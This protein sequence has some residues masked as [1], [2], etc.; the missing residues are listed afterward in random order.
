ML[1][2]FT[3]KMGAGAILVFFVIGYFVFLAWFIWL[4]V[5]CMKGLKLVRKGMRHP[6]PD[7]WGF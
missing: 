4:V 5:P 3:A 2:L 6:A 1:N 7:T